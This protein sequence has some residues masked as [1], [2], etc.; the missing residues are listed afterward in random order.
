[1]GRKKEDIKFQVKLTLTE[2]EFIRF[3]EYQKRR[4]IEGSLPSAI[5]LAAMREV[6]GDNL[7]TQD[8]EL[9]EKV[10]RLKTVIEL[11]DLLH[12]FLTRSEYRRVKDAFNLLDIYY[13]KSLLDKNEELKRL[14]DGNVFKTF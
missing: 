8:K 14:F 7:I 5:V 11:S 12:S 6:T 3:E 4:N 1:M 9:L 10:S 2:N 13:D